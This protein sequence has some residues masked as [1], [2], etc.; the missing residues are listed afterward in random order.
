M[1]IEQGSAGA[2][3]AAVAAFTPRPMRLSILTAALQEL[4]PRERRDADPDLA[5]EEW[6]GFAREIGAPNIELSAA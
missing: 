1:R 2:A 4:T 3:G 5:V 6:L